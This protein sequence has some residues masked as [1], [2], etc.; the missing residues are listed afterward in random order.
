YIGLIYADGNAMGR[1]VQELDSRETCATFSRLVDGS[2]REAC[3][4]ALDDAC[5]PEIT[6]QR[7]NP[8]T[9]RELP[10]DI[11][12][13]GGDDLLVL[14]PAD[15]ALGFALDVT[16]QFEETTRQRMAESSGSVREFFAKH[17]CPNKGLTIS[18]GVAL[19]PAKYPFY[20]LLDLA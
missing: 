4:A 2:I 16:R 18:C 9:A 1:L 19:A 8:G 20:L 3:Y 10:A 14:L 12:L 11:L 15:L 6:A 5:A 7:Q 17:T 13:V